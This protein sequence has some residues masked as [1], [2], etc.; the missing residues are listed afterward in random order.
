MNESSKKIRRSLVKYYKDRDCVT[1]VRPAYEE[2][3]LQNLNQLPSHQLRREFIEGVNSLRDRILTNCGPKRY[4]DTPLYGGSI[5]SMIESYVNM[6]NKG[7]IPS[8]RTA[9]EQ[10]N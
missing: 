7:A 10:I 3:D 2:E 1:L 6:M 8:I 9:W 5:A 4:D